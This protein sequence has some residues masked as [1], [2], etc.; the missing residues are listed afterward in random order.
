MTSAIRCG[1]AK[2][3]VEEKDGDDHGRRYPLRVRR[4]RRQGVPRFLTCVRGSLL[5]LWRG[6]RRRR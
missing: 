5:I 4:R 2:D 6:R 3:G 1:L